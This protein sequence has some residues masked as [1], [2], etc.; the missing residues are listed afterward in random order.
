VKQLLAFLLFCLAGASLRGQD[1]MDYNHSRP[2][3]M[4]MPR[5]LK[6]SPGNMLVGPIPLYTAAYGIIYETPVAK[7]QSIQVGCS[8]IGKGLYWRLLEYS[9]SAPP[10]GINLIETGIEFQFAYKFFLSKKKRLAPRG[11]YVGP[12]FHSTTAN[13]GTSYGYRIQGRYLNLEQFDANIMYG[14][15]LM[16]KSGRGFVVDFF[17]AAG[18]KNITGVYQQG[19]GAS[20]PYSFAG[21]GLLDTH[22]N[23]LIG[24]N[25]GW[26]F[27]PK[28]K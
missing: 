7:K 16:R 14:C 21:D 6:I 13:V 2:E 5:I 28:K 4:K 15:Q 26:G 25:I 17:A 19:P 8:I 23:F 9:T 11:W 22:V 12:L 18:Y 20:V 27:C 10:Y 1:L 24:L 3:P